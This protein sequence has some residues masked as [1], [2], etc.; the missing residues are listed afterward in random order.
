MLI[1]LG[2]KSDKNKIQ[3]LKQKSYQNIETKNAFTLTNNNNR[4]SKTLLQPQQ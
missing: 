2:T 4:N 1:G 3:G